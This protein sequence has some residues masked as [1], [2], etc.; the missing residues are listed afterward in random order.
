[1][2]LELELRQ[3]IIH[4]DISKKS[5]AHVAALLALSQPVS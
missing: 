2:Q 1:L 4:A 3:T 5:E